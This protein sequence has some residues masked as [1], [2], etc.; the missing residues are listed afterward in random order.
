MFLECDIILYAVFLEVSWNLED[1]KE[2]GFTILSIFFFWF[3]TQNKA[4]K[5]LKFFEYQNQHY[6]QIIWKW[7]MIANSEILDTQKTYSLMKVQQIPHILEDQR[8][9]KKKS[10][11]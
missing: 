3:T 9:K 5:I 10:G 6:L 8:K 1:I 7:T 4:A 2:F 11:V